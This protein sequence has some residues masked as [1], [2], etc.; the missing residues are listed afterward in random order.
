M[1]A[2][3]LNLNQVPQNWFKVAYHSN[4]SLLEWLDDL[5]RRC[6][7]F[8]AWGDEFEVPNVMWISGLFN[9]MS[10]LTAIIQVTARKDMLP[11][12]DMHLKT[13]VLNVFDPEEQTSKAPSGAY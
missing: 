3:S 7:Q 10:Y 5:I 6:D 1:G 4:K 8:N 11:L 12:D 9:P 2:A 13:D